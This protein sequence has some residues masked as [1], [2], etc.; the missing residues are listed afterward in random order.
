MRKEPLIVDYYTD[1][2][3]VWAWIRQRRIDELIS[4]FA[5]KIEI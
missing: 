2:L 1:I 5:D 4:H 3:Y